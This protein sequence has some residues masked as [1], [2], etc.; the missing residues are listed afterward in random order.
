M[1]IMKV[2]RFFHINRITFSWFIGPNSI[3]RAAH[4]TFHLLLLI[5]F[6]FLSFIQMDFHTFSFPLSRAT[7]VL[8]NSKW[9]IISSAS[10]ILSTLDSHHSRMKV[11]MKTF[12]WDL[13]ENNVTQL[14]YR[15][16]KTRNS[17]T[18]SL[19]GKFHAKTTLITAK[20]KTVVALIWARRWTCDFCNGNKHKC[21]A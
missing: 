4:R 6:S 21:N 15:F 5:P 10:Q 2:L 12:G 17:S 1:Q 19:K 16:N 13:C 8:I 14:C 9:V 18:T 11:E 3:F 7:L 20:G